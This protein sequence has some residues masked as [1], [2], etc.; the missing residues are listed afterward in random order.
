MA[1]ALDKFG[2]YI[3]LMFHNNLPVFI[4]NDRAGIAL[5]GFHER[6]RRVNIGIQRHELEH[7][8]EQLGHRV[9]ITADEALRIACCGEIAIA[10]D[11]FIA[12]AHLHQNF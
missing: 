2:F 3:F 6:D 5:C 11:D 7:S 10:D 12:V 1:E 9:P 4:P 8:V